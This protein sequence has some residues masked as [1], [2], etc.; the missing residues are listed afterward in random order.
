MIDHASIA[1]YLDFLKSLVRLDISSFSGNQSAKGFLKPYLCSCS[2]S[3][4]FF[5]AHLCSCSEMLFAAY[6]CSCSEMLF[7]AYSCSC[8]EIGER[9][10]PCTPFHNPRFGLESPPRLLARISE[11]NPKRFPVLLSLTPSR[12]RCCCSCHRRVAV[13]QARKTAA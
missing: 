2:G 7:A 10:I 12:R 1:S 11:K 9:K 13:N 3:E 4:M 8:S 6:L 5:A